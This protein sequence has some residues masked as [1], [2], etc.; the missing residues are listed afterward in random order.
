MA[1]KLQAAA[2]RLPDVHEILARPRPAQ[3]WDEILA[4]RID[5]LAA[6]AASGDVGGYDPYTVTYPSTCH[7]VL[8][9]RVAKKAPEPMHWMRVTPR[10]CRRETPFAA[11]AYPAR[12]GTPTRGTHIELEHLEG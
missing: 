8:T 9:L 4:R 10:R 3:L 12:S 6:C 11:S 7:S 1:D 5:R 2:S